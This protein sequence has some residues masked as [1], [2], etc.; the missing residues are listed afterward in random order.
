MTS[1]LIP[2]GFRNKPSLEQQVK[3]LVVSLES[4]WTNW[5]RT[6]MLYKKD[7]YAGKIAELNGRY[8]SL[9]GHDY[10]RT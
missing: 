6:P 4:N 8:K 7:F 2:P 3:E 1:P 5:E 10:K 9:T